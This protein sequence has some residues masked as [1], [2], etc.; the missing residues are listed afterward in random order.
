MIIGADPRDA[1]AWCAAGGRRTAGRRCA[2][3]RGQRGR[4]RGSGAPRARGGSDMTSAA[5]SL[6]RRD[7]LDLIAAKL[8]RA[9]APCIT[10]QLPG[11]V[12]RAGPHAAQVHAGHPGAV[13]RH[14]A[15]LPADA[16][17]SRRARRRKWGLNLVTLRAAEPA[18]GLWQQRPQG[19]LRQA[20]GASRSS[21]RSSSY[22]TWFTGLRRDQS[23]TRAKLER[24]R[25]VH[26]ADRQGRCA[27]SARWRTGARRT[28]G[29]TRRRNDIPLLPLYELGYTSIGCEP[30]TSLPLDPANERSGRWRGQK[31]ECGIHYREARDG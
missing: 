12:R 5:E 4:S 8:A 10:S 27:R 26:A 20:Q 18:P 30:C 29:R 13:P 1:A 11:R 24:G 17:L 6:G 9:A 22:D 31:L 28:S 2:R 23:P 14:R 16:R 21:A 19:L 7:A 15:S 3:R 25:A